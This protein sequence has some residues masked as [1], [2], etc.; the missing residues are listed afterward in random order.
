MTE[1]SEVPKTLE[2]CI[3]LRGSGDCN[4]C[5]YKPRKIGTIRNCNKHMSLKNF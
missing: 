4:A 5:G 1:I 3:K 2:R